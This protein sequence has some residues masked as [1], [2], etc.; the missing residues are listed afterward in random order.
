MF[1]DLFFVTVGS[2]RLFPRLGLSKTLCAEGFLLAQQGCAILG[3]KNSIKPVSFC[4]KFT[5]DLLHSL[6]ET[7]M[8]PPKAQF[9]CAEKS[10]LLEE[11]LGKSEEVRATEKYYNEVLMASLS[12][13]SAHIAR[14]RLR[15]AKQAYREAR[16]RYLSH[17]KTHFC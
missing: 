12:G 4:T 16:H 14:E 6:Y 3:E 15:E 8:E 1:S 7:H 13:R 17:V 5:I 11:Y 2:G 9:G 10:R